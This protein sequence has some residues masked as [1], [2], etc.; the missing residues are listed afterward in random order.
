MARITESKFTVFDLETTGL[1][2]A[3]DRIIELGITTFEHGAMVRSGRLLFNPHR[4][5]SEGARQTHGICDVHLEDKPDFE[6]VVERVI[7]DFDTVPAI[8]GYNCLHFDVPLL[9]AEIARTGRDWRVPRDSVIDVKSFVDWHHRGLRHR[10]QVDLAEFYEIVMCGQAHSA[11]ADSLLTGE[12]LL[13]MVARGRV[14]D[15][16]AE[17]VA[18]GRGFTETVEKEFERWSYWAYRCRQTRRLRAGAGKH[19][20]RFLSEVPKSYLSFLLNKK[21]LHEG[22]RVVLDDAH[23]RRVQN[24]LQRPMVSDQTDTNS[25]TVGWGGWE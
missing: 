6:T 20:G 21:D 4:P 23:A 16:V 25:D 3:E 2:T 13:K 15:D 19:V 22:A 5:I 1:D 18:E 11:A 10:R 9:E 24:E 14:P 7:S 8:V 12:L 17:A